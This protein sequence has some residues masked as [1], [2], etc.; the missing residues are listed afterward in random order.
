MNGDATTL[1]ITVTA[2]PL[3]F[4]VVQK[5]LRLGPVEKQLDW[6]TDLS[7]TTVSVIESCIASAE[8]TIRMMSIAAQRDLVATYGYMDGEHAFSAT[9]VL[10]MACGAFPT[11]TQTTTAMNAGLALLR[12]MGQ[13]G[14]STMNQRYEALAHLKSIILP[15]VVDDDGTA[16]LGLFSSPSPPHSAS[17][18][19]DVAI[20]SVLNFSP[21]QCSEYQKPFSTFAVLGI[22]ELGDMASYDA[23]MG[24]VA[25]DG[26]FGLWEEGFGNPTGFDISQWTQAAEMAVDRPEEEG[27]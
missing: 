2:R 18:G 3:L 16:D 20:G 8:D 4:H 24:S 21:S 6:R 17:L 15:G 14:N 23:S 25:G 11:N 13:R 1:T 7:A 22:G 5:R 19:G 9:I 10:V 12:G 27:I 26:D